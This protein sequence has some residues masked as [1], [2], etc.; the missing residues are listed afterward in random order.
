MSLC[1]SSSFAVINPQV[2]ALFS[3]VCLEFDSQRKDNL[4]TRFATEFILRED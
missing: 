4:C 1:H 3:K 2:K